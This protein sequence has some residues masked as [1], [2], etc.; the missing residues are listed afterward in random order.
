MDHEDKIDEV[1]DVQLMTQFLGVVEGRTIE[2]FEKQ[3][4][5]FN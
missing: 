1:T 3:W 5:T 2:E 4:G